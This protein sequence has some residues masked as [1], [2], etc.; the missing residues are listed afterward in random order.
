MKAPGRLRGDGW[1]RFLH[2][3]APAPTAKHPLRRALITGALFIVFGGLLSVIG[4]SALTA[5]VRLDE[6]RVHVAE[7]AAARDASST[8]AA[9]AWKALDS[10]DTAWAGYAPN[11]LRVQTALG[12]PTVD[13]HAFALAFRVRLVEQFDDLDPADALAVAART[14]VQSDEFRVKRAAFLGSLRDVRERIVELSGVLND[15]LEHP[16]A[17]F[18]SSQADLVANFFAA[19]S[20]L[21]SRWAAV[22]AAARRASD[23]STAAAFRAQRAYEQQAR[24][25]IFD[26]VL[27]P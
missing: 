15:I 2:D 5:M 1:S 12:D 22:R 21:S 13:A 25:D 24:K 8:A 3:A 27:D 20:I 11:L 7:L 19:E 10:L 23:A 18:N 26:A 17:R 16:G 4:E 9:A 14:Q 6:H